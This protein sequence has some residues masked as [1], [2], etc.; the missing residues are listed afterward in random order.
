MSRANLV[1][2]LLQVDD[3]LWRSSEVDG[4]SLVW[5]PLLAISESGLWLGVDKSGQWV[6]GR[7]EGRVTPQSDVLTQSW[8]PILD[9]DEGQ[10][11]ERLATAATIHGLAAPVI[12]DLVPVDDIVSLALRS[13][14]KHWTERAVKWLVNR[15]P[16]IDH[17]NHLRDI[18]EAR[19]ASQ[20][21]RQAAH[22]LT[23]SFDRSAEGPV[24][25][26]SK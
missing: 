2:E 6:V 5:L 13:G 19:W 4:A 21:T 16:R 12:Q 24:T 11:R 17:V 15:S 25:G 23:S 10:F 22:R 7:P 18:A 20:W 9:M 1:R 3:S 14:S 26:A 8:L